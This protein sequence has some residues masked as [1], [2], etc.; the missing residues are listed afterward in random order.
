MPAWWVCVV[1]A[2]IVLFLCGVSTN[3]ILSKIRIFLKID[4]SVYSRFMF[5]EGA[6]VLCYGQI[7]VQAKEQLKDGKD[8]IKR[9]N[10]F[11]TQ[12]LN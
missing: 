12:Q 9:N 2:S 3:L 5:W 4:L 7:F 11:P 1:R 8:S 6:D 10:H